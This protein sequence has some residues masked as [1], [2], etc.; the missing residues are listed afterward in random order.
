M[1]PANFASARENAFRW[2]VAERGREGHWLWRWKFKT[3]DH[4]VRF[5]PEKY[6]WPWTPGSASWVIPTAFSV[7]ALKQYTVCN[8]LEASEKRIKLDVEM[9]LDRM[10]VAGGWNS[11][12]SVVYGVNQLADWENLCRKV[13]QDTVGFGSVQTLHIASLQ[14]SR[15]SYL[16]QDRVWVK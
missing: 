11:G 10:C 15:D 6:G 13:S 5:D 1:G 3:A 16:Q 9:L 4:K 2:L 12:N 8:R 7:I 14:R